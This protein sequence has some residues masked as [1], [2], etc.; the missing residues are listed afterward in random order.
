MYLPGDLRGTIQHLCVGRP[1]HGLFPQKFLLAVQ[2]DKT[3]A[4]V[5]GRLGPPPLEITS[6]CCFISVYCTRSPGG[7]RRDTV[8]GPIA[9]LVRTGGA[10]NLKTKTPP[11]NYG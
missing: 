6:L 3:Q 1:R 10:V 7:G 5:F 9:V 2:E 4:A 11:S 8:V